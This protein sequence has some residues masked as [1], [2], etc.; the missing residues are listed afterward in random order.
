MRLRYKLMG[1]QIKRLLL[2]NRGLGKE[3]ETFYA[4]A[5]INILRLF[6]FISKEKLIQSKVIEYS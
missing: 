1:M 5:R 6:N 3:G 4:Y 2:L